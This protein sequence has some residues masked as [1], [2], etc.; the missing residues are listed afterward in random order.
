MESKISIKKNAFY[1]VIKT[2]SVIIF[3]LITF[4]Y[5]SRVLLTENIGKYNFSTTFVNYFSLLAALGIATY[6][7]RI[8]S[9]H[10]DNKEELSNIASQIFSINFLFTLIAYAALLAVLLFYPAIHEYQT[11]ILIIGASI[12]FSTL[13]ADWINS[14]LEDFKYITIRTFAF[15][16]VSLILMFIFVREQDDYI[17]YAI[18]TV[19]SSSGANILNIFYRKKYCKIRFTFRIDWK[20]H[21]PPI[22]FLAVMSLSQTILGNADTTMLGLMIGDYEVGIYTTAHKVEQIISQVVSSLLWVF[23]PR[24]AYLFR[25]GNYS[26]INSLLSKIFSVFLLIGLPCVAGAISIADNIILL[27]AGEA[28]IGS[29]PVLQIL[30]LSFLFSLVGGSFFGNMVLLP[31]GKER[32]FMIICCIAAVIN[33]SLNFV[34]IPL[35]GASG[36]ALTTAFSSLVIMSATVIVKDKRIKLQGVFRSLLAPCIGSILIVVFCFLIKYLHIQ[37]VI[38]TVVCI[39]GSIVIYIAILFLLRNQAAYSALGMLRRKMKTL[40]KTKAQKTERLLSRLKEVA[41]IAIQKKKYERA[42]MAISAAAQISYEYN[43]FYVGTELE[44]MLAMIAEHMQEPDAECV[45]HNRILFYDAFGF[46]T[47]GVALMYLN[48]LQ[49]N[50]YEIVYVTAR[51]KID[52]QPRIDRVLNGAHYFKE[53]IDSQQPYLV[54]VQQLNALFMKYKPGSAFYYTYPKDVVG[55]LAFRLQKEHCKRYLIDLTDHAFWL[56]A[57]FFDYNFEFRCYGKTVSVEK[58]ALKEE[59]LLYLPYYPIFP[60]APIEFQGFPNFPK[61]SIKIFT[62]GSFYKMFGRNGE[63]FGIIDSLLSLSEKVIVLIAGSGDLRLLNHQLHNLIHRDRIYYIGNRKDINE[64]FRHI[65]IYLDTYPVNGGLMEQYAIANFKPILVYGQYTELSID[66]QYGAGYIPKFSSEN[67]FLDYADKLISD[68]KY[69]IAEATRNAK[70]VQ[71]E[72]VFNETFIRLVSTN[73]SCMQCRQIPIDYEGKKQLY[74]EIE[75]DFTHLGIWSIIRGCKLSILKIFPKHR[76]IFLYV[77]VTYL[78]RK[79]RLI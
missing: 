39:A 45:D 41:G 30:M 64:V 42:L 68:D 46:D 15:Q 50:G 33:V 43:Q 16:V 37:F 10:R 52:H 69:R 1:N 3:P 28:Y 4:P 76:Y 29:Q 7:I 5:V 35:Y 38:E 32:T 51:D 12:M 57:S 65:D 24:L 67:E 61:D 77:L 73:D 49:K 8:C 60:K 13:G 19:V 53:S 47:R 25:E 48:A 9:Q 17:N 18:I 79:F 63:F 20:K 22:I 23:M 62:G 74:L 36:A 75:N 44:E 59:Q 21:L 56:G 54:Q 27:I 6:A 70:C 58:R 26:D 71:G 40:K 55:W 11:L 34:V 66:S 78:L 31:S 72:K 14:A 2:L